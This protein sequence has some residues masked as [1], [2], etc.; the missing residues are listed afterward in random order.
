MSGRLSPTQLETLQWIA[1][2]HADGDAPNTRRLS[3]RSLHHRELV[4]VRGRGP[5]WR[6]TITDRGREW[7]ANGGIP[8]P[9]PTQEPVVGHAEPVSPPRRRGRPPKL[10]APPPDTT[11]DSPAGKRRAGHRPRGDGLFTKESPDPWDEKIL[12]NVKEAAWMLSLPESAIRHAVT[13]GEVDRVFIGEGGKN[14]RIVYGSLLAWVN[15]MPRSSARR[16]W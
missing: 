8:A 10:K 11:V 3:A 16:W 2:G 1:D 9:T 6:A 13:S 4:V 15:D 12:V 7:L 5:Q 14:Y